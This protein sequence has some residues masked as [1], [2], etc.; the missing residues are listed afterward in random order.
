[1]ENSVSRLARGRANFDAEGHAA[2]DR[3]QDD[4]LTLFPR[5]VPMTASASRAL[6]LSVARLFFASAG[7]LSPRRLSKSIFDLLNGRISG[8]R[9]ISRVGGGMEDPRPRRRAEEAGAS[10]ECGCERV[11]GSGTPSPRHL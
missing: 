4:A 3:A 7:Q 6:P 10:G 9:E 2:R 8:Q 11:I 1:M 5:A